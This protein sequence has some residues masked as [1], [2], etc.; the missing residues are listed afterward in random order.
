LNLRKEFKQCAGLAFE[1]QGYRLAIHCIAVPRKDLDGAE[2]KDFQALRRQGIFACA[3]RMD[4]GTL[5]L[6][7]QD[8]VRA[9][10]ETSN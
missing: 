10:N 1:R 5:D 8:K 7:E 4:M 9:Y 3:G 2:G 6:C